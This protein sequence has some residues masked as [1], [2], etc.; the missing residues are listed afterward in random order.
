[1]SVPAYLYSLPAMN[2]TTTAADLRH[3][4]E[5]LWQSQPLPGA[6]RGGADPLRLLHELHVHQIELAMQNDELRAARDEL[7]TEVAHYTDLYDFA[8]V[9]YLTLDTA[10]KIIRANL[11]A[12]SLLCVERDRLIGKRF[13]IFVAGTDRAAVSDCL[14]RLF[15]EEPEQSCVVALEAGCRPDVFVELQASRAGDGGECRL[16][17]H[18]ITDRMLTEAALKESRARWRFISQGPSDAV[19]EWDVATSTVFFSPWW[20]Q[21]LGYAEDE[22]GAELE[23]WSIRIHPDDLPGVM[24]NL[25]PHLDGVTAAYASEHRLRCKDGSHRWVFARGLVISRDPEGQPL[26]MV[27]AHADR[28]R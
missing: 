20:K 23:E 21:L 22:I 7:E 3:R 27:A 17:L 1:M 18:D 19:W 6:P 25:Q 15:T 10:G 4:A 24:A 26:R 9:G 13:A 28:G 8:P 2:P 12:A 16:V 14:D 11:L 5:L